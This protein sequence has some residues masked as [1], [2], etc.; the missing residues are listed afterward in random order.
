MFFYDDEGALKALPAGWTDANQ[1]DPFV[2]LA[3]GRAFFRPADLLEL[4]ALAVHLRGV[5]SAPE[6]G[7][8]V[9]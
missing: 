6:G 3:G 7:Q 1:P 8:H 9:R 5:G 4:A 2:T